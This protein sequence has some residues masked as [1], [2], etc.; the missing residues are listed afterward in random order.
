MEAVASGNDIS[1]KQFTAEL[2][3]NKFL[4]SQFEFQQTLNANFSQQEQLNFRATLDFVEKTFKDTHD[5]IVKRGLYPEK[6]EKVKTSIEIQKELEVARKRLFNSLDSL[7]KKGKNYNPAEKPEPTEVEG[8]V[9][10]E[11]GVYRSK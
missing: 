6:G 3:A 5:E 1:I 10:G 4:R 2:A 7:K 8:L 11:D 9:K